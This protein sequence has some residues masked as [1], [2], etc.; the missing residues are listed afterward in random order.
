[1]VGASGSRREYSV[2]GDAVNTGIRLM[3][4][5]PV[6]KILIDEETAKEAS[7]KIDLKHYKKMKIKGKAEEVQTYEPEENVPMIRISNPFFPQNPMRLC[8]VDRNVMLD[9]I[10]TNCERFLSSETNSKSLIELVGPFGS[11]KSFTLF[12]VLNSV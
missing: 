1:M 10:R 9:S 11:G 3:Q 2:L 12:M 7:A 6:S 5:A 8:Y 4:A